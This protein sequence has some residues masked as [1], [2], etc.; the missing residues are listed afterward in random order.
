M[1]TSD[2]PSGEIGSGLTIVLLQAILT[3]MRMTL[4]LAH[5]LLTS[6]VLVLADPAGAGPVERAED[7]PEPVPPE[8]YSLYDQVIQT[9]FLTSRTSL[10]MIERLTV[11]RLGPEE[12]NP[13]DRAY[14]DENRFFEGRLEP[15]L[16]A[17]FLLKTRRPSR[18]EAKFHFGVPYRFVS[19]GELE[20][21]EVSLG[22]IP[23][24]FSPTDLA[25][26]APPTIGIL[27]FSRVGFNRREDQALIYVGDNRPDGSGAGLLV[28]LHRRGRVWTIVNTEVLWVA[29]RE[30]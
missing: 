8:E 27:E 24:E 13:P 25:Q 3:C 28:L 23:A 15:D 19:D 11:T 17:D 4:P 12:R 16:V 14:F 1:Q 7:R 5:L 30:E 21:P 26:D 22:P 20:E 9:K 10:V 18:L 2:V 6:F 29:R